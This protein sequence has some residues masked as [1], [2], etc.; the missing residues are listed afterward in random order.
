MLDKTS[1]A[2]RNI[3]L[4]VRSIL[5]L[6]DNRRSAIKLELTAAG[7]AALLLVFINST[8]WGAI[9][10]ICAFLCAGA[11]KSVDNADLWGE[12]ES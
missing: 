10:L 11:I 2:W 4:W 8:L 7:V 5:W 1:E 12:N 6:V 3:P 9:A